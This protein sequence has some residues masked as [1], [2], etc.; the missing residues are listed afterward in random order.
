M[1]KLIAAI[2]NLYYVLFPPDLLTVYKKMGVEIGKNCNFQFGVNI[3]FSHYWLVKIGNNVTLAPKV[4]ILAHDAS[5]KIKLNYTKIALVEIEDNVFIGAGSIILP[6]V[7]IGKNSIIGAGSIVTKDVPANSLAA[8]CPAKVITL[9]DDYIEKQKVFMTKENCFDESYTLRKN[10][11]NDKKAEM[12]DLL[13][14]HKVGF[15]E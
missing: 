7:K 12:I 15:V 13:R 8:G 5:T 4:H 3:D 2:K 14:K 1:K 9:A 10:I 6:G 11:S